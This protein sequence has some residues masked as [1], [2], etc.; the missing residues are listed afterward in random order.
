MTIAEKI[1]RAKADYD[2][3]YAAGK[4]AAYDAFWDDFQENGKRVDYVNAFSY[5]NWRG[6]CYNPK[7]P[8]IG[9]GAYGVQECFRN[10]AYITDTKVPIIIRKD[11]LKTVFHQCFSLKRVPSFVLEVPVT[12][13]NLTFNQ[14]YALEEL[15][16]ECVGDG[17]IAGDGLTFTDCTKLNKASITSVI[18]ALSTT[19]TGLTVTLSKT[20]VNNAFATAEGAADGS[21]SVEWLALVATRSNWTIALA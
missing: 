18:N 4:Q 21:T 7:Y 6:D 12:Q 8:I 19:T 2:E 9:G 5:N 1:T 17:C 14:C 15:N 13:Y 11:N 16:I 3:V 10:N 20:A